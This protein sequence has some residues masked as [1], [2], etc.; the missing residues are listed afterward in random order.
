MVSSS[1]LGRLLGPR[2]CADGGDDSGEHQRRSS[3]RRVSSPS[4]RRSTD[5]PAL[6]LSSRRGGQAGDGRHRALAQPER[7]SEP[8]VPVHQP[9][10]EQRAGQPAPALDQQRADPAARGA[11][12][13]PS[14][15]LSRAHDRHA[16]SLQP[17][18]ARGGRPRRRPPPSSGL[19]R[20]AHQRRADGRRSAAGGRRP[21]GAGGLGADAARAR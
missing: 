19:A 20:G 1:P 3:T 13:A 17:P 11:P 6:G 12:T 8:V 16:R 5:P 21:P 2:D 15:R 10:R 9:R 14:S 7:R 18:D 4:A